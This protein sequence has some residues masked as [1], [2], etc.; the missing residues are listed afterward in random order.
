MNV[1]KEVSLTDFTGKDTYEIFS[2][3]MLFCRSNPGTTLKIP[4][5]EYILHVPEAR[6]L[7]DDVMN[8]VYGADPEPVVF[9]RFFPYAVG[10]DLSG[11]RDVTIHAQNV[12]LLFD[13]WLEAIS[14]SDCENIT[15]HGL[16]IDYVRKPYSAGVV[17]EITGDSFTVLF[18]E[19]YPV[20]ESAPND[21]LMFYEGDDRKPIFSPVYGAQSYAGEQQLRFAGHLPEMFLGKRLMSRHMFHF[22]PAILIYRSKNIFLNGTQIYSQPGMGIVGFRSENIYIDRLRIVPSD[23]YEPISTNTDATHFSSCKGMLS[24]RDSVFSHHG[25]DAINVHGYYHSILSIQRE[26]VTMQTIE[27]TH[28]AKLDSPEPGEYLLSN[29]TQR[30]SLDFTGCT[31]LNNLARAVLI[32]T[33]NVRIENCTFRFC[34]GTAIHIA[35]EKSWRESGLSKNVVIRNNEMLDC[36]YLEQGVIMNASGIAIN[37]E[38]DM[39]E[40]VGLQQNITIENNRIRCPEGRTGIYIAN[41][42]NVTVRQNDIINTD[43]EIII[44]YSRGITVD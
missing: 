13:G 21:R 31:T 10:L 29:L 17:T 43:Q 2:A 25:D 9:N 3:A 30:P 39:Y 18:D 33:D 28:A 23:A 38:T 20:T 37:V 22:R 42:E 34:T 35:A 12:K 40:K 44:A 5:G 36:G 24:V 26:K 7:Q 41:A 32:K 19:R 6:R 16:S 8:G 11:A 27:L 4:A 1:K 14:L 15:I